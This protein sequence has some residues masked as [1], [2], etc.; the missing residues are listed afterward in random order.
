MFGRERQDF[1]S[2]TGGTAWP[3]QFPFAQW[4]RHMRES[5]G[6]AGAAARARVMA[7]ALASGRRLD[8]WSLALVMLA[9]FS[10]LWMLLPPSSAI[11]LLLSLLAGGTQK[12]FALRVAFDQTL[13]RHWDETWTSAATQGR[14]APTFEADLTALDQ[15][16]VACGLLPQQ[17]GAARS[18]DSRLHG[19]WRLLK[20]QV[21]A[22]AIQLATMIGA[23]V[24]LQLLPAS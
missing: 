6:I 12:L 13:F 14:D 23:A 8:L 17:G 11:C 9:L 3:W 19:A 1:R 10:L 2:K 22:F 5:P 4:R 24:A 7:A 20:R 15:T 18:L 16:L 21:L